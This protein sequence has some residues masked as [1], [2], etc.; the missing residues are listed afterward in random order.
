MS[1]QNGI[2]HYAQVS[3]QETITTASPHRLVQ[4]LMEG[5]IERINFAQ[6]KIQQN[7]FS[8]KGRFITKAID[9]INGLR[10]SLNFE[11][12]GE[13]AEDFERLY[14]FMVRRLIEANRDNDSSGLAEV[15][16][17]LKEIKDAWDGVPAALKE[18]S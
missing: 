16:N 4:M 13:I 8:E 10:G 7:N 14:E 15:S 2:E 12:G 6:A 1:K 17:L 5:A 11:K 9:I 3:A 18:Q